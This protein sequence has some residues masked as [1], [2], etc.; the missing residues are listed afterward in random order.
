MNL[1]FKI[2]LLPVLLSAFGT[3]SFAQQFGGNPA[4]IH[5][6]Q[7]NTD[8][9]RVIFPEG[10]DNAGTK[11]SSIVHDLQKNHAATV[12]PRLH[13]I[14]IVLQNQTAVSNA[15]VGLGPFRSEFYLFP[16]QN[17]FTLGS[18]NWTETL[19]LHEFRHVQQYNNYNVGLSKA[20]GVI[21]GQEGRA[22]MNAAAVP[23]WFFEGDAVFNETVLSRQ[24]RGR[25]PDFFNGYQSLFRQGRKYSYMKLRNGSF[26]DYVPNHYPLGYLL[27]GYGRERFGTDVWRKVTHDAAAFKSIIYPF[28]SSFK[29]NTGV[30]YKQFVKDAFQFYNDKWQL[31]KGNDLNY[32]TPVNKNNVT[33]YKYPYAQ[34]DG[35]IIVL[36][37]SYRQI[38]AFY[39]INANGTQEKIAVRD[40]ANDDYFSDNNGKIAY[41]SYNRDKRWGYREFSDI[42]VM[43]IATK[44]THTI[45]HQGRFFSPDISHDGLRVIAVDMRTNGVSDLIVMNL[46]GEITFRSKATRG[47]IYTMPKFSANDSFVYTALRNEEGQMALSKIE[48][49]SGKET[50]PLPFAN[51]IIGFSTVNGDTVLFS[52][53]YKGSDEIWAYIDSRKQVYRV[54]INPTG[55]YQATYNPSSKNIV[56]SNFTADGYRLAGISTSAQLWQAVSDKENPLPDLYIPK[57]LAQQN[58]ATLENIPFRSFPIAKYRKSYNLL[59]FHSWRPYYDESEISLTL[60][61]ENILNTLQSQL[62]YTYNRNESSHRAGFNAIYGGTY[63]QPLAGI[64]QT[65]DRNVVY[66]RDTTF[67]YNEFNANAGLS[68]PLNFSSGKHFRSLTLTS[69]I[70]NQQVK[71]KGIG[72]GLLRNQ[73]FFFVQNRV[74]YSNQV[75]R[76]Q[77]QIYPRWGQTILLQ[78]RSIIQKFIGNQ[79]LASGFLYLPGI[80][81]NHNL[82]LSGAYQARDTAGEYAFTNNFPFSRGYTGV[83]FPRMFRFGSNYHLPLVYPDWGFANIVY[84]KRIRANAFYDLTIGKSLRTG[85]TTNFSTTGAELFFDTRWWNQQEVSFGIRYSRL[86]DKQFR[87]ITQ[88][89]QWEIILPVGLFQ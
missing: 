89:N 32:I 48:L 22:L 88:P 26:K 18:L 60:L 45:T 25:I 34:A 73:D 58:N 79:F 47:I 78:H 38:P 50:F 23:D 80:K 87:G 55:L 17:S 76:A 83:D 44:Q 39:K 15:Y 56:A 35:S 1:L 2:L 52:S 84:F 10:L 19:A 31:A 61:G 62:S 4:S 74:V 29:K 11:V 12:G 8:T 67:F 72:K 51:R 70:N 13:K 41:T 66:N 53:S 14:N 42:K 21:F 82:V 81:S 65:W 30:A 20:V 28:Q 6:K 5:W 59:N 3:Y 33:D 43:D 24:G 54:A 85:N 57:A 75:Q 49:S 7:I 86:L 69:T 37:R 9:A 40:I 77:Q 46:H 68:L 64:S 63:I 71:W 27:V 36:K 16:P